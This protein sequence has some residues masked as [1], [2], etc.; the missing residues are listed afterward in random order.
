ML[1]LDHALKRT[2]RDNKNAR[3]HIL[4]VLL[5]QSCGAVPR[6]TS[7][8]DISAELNLNRDTVN[9]ALQA[10]AHDGYAARTEQGWIATTLAQ[11][12]PL[13]SLLNAGMETRQ[14]GLLPDAAGQ[15]EMRKNSASRR[16]ISAPSVVVVDQQD[17]DLKDQQQQPN[18]DA[19]KLR[20]ALAAAGIRPGKQHRALMAD[21][22]VTADRVSA[23]QRHVQQMLESGEAALDNPAGYIITRLLEQDE[24]PPPPEPRPRQFSAF[25]SDKELWERQINDPNSAAYRLMHRDAIEQE[26]SND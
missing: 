18:N 2:L 6:A 3:L 10:M 21:P 22:W 4:I 13:P 23:W 15:D 17:H 5:Y 26:E 16:K 24:P 25:A 12:L 7:A 14:S 11:Q 19:E 8:A 20:A 9:D 1:Q